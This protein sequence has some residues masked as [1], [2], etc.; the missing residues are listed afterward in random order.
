MLTALE[1]TLPSGWEPT[2][3]PSAVF[4]PG[5]V[6]R[7]GE[8]GSHQ[9][10]IEN[11][12][13]A[14]ASVFPYAES[15]VTAKLKAGAS[16]PIGISA[17]GEIL[18][19]VKLADPQH[20]LVSETKMV[21]SVECRA[22]LVQ[23]NSNPETLSSLYLVKESLLAQI[24]HQTCY[25]LNAKGMVVAEVEAEQECKI[26]SQ[27]PIAFAMRTRR[28]SEV[29]AFRDLL[30]AAAAPTAPAGEARTGV[31][32]RFESEPSGAQV[33]VDR[34]QLSG[35]LTPCSRELTKGIHDVRF[36]KD[37]YK[38][39]SDGK[40][41][42]EVTEN[43]QLVKRILEPNF[44]QL[45]VRSDPSGVP[46][47]LDGNP[48]GSTPISKMRVTP[49]PHVLRVT[50]ECFVNK[51]YPVKIDQN[52]VNL[53]VGPQLVGVDL[54]AKDSQENDLAAEVFVD[55]KREGLTPSRVFVPRCAQSVELR[56][57]DLYGNVSMEAIRTAG[58]GGAQETI[59]L[60]PLHQARLVASE[61]D[62][63]TTIRKRLK[64]RK[65]HS[66]L[67]IG[68]SVLTASLIASL[69]SYQQAKSGDVSAEDWQ[70]VQTLNAVGWVGVAAG[71]GIFGWGLTIPNEPN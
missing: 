58:P 6:M 63:D 48:I 16:L 52:D 34:A 12:F 47:L 9:S 18:K 26:T 49:T 36:T 29:P 19:H 15:D 30:S 54:K 50:G 41:Q 55:D 5:T 23:A 40:A 61:N 28:L 42:V 66:V 13:G 51:D 69:N 21:P 45:T 56:Y 25:K 4:V 39:T 22:A 1:D 27:D 60:L 70:S 62:V 14:D 57:N 32:V 31:V 10:F 38:A 43:N 3:E 64:W 65:K 71:V 59:T 8:D 20:Q 35:C 7:I 2:P 24:T 44:R 17:K 68:G 33:H 37:D 46:L 11:C 67:A 53:K